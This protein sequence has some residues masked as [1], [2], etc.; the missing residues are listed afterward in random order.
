MTTKPSKR[1]LMINGLLACGWREVKPAPSRKYLA[2]D[3]NDGQGRMFVGG[4]GALRWSR[5][6]KASDSLSMTDNFRHKAYQEIGNPA[7][8]F[9]DTDQAVEAYRAVVAGKP[10]LQDMLVPMPTLAHEIRQ[11]ITA[12]VCGQ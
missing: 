10:I 3:R 2:Y 11:Q 1:Q 8:R 7:Y 6:G 9:V 12:G 4:S 5:T